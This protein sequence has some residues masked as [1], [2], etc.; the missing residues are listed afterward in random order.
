MLPSSTAT[1]LAVFG[2]ILRNRPQSSSIRIWNMTYFPPKRDTLACRESLDS[3]LDIFAGICIS[4]T[5]IITD[6]WTDRHTFGKE[7]LATDV[8]RD[9]NIAYK[10][11]ILLGLQSLVYY[12]LI[13]LC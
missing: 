7:N 10:K 13:V 3:V 12:L 6:G 8:W 5:G 4:E 1:T 9:M 2:G 11:R